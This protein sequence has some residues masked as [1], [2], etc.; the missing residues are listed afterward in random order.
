M[1]IIME[2]TYYFFIC[3]SDLPLRQHWWVKTPGRLSGWPARRRWQRGCCSWACQPNW[4]GP[5]VDVAG[6]D[7]RRRGKKTEGNIVRVIK[8]KK[9][10]YFFFSWKVMQNVWVFV[11]RGGGG[12]YVR[13]QDIRIIGSE[14]YFKREKCLFCLLWVWRKIISFRLC[15]YIPSFFAFQFLTTY[16]CIR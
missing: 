15:R 4:G 5:G 9:K 3:I 1:F 6:T 2:A 12:I 16:E 13:S 8:K 14:N 11:G 7:A 10:T